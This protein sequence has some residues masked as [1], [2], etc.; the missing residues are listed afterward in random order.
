MASE[1]LLMIERNGYLMRWDN[2]RKRYVY[3]HRLVM[4]AH[5]GRHLRSDELVHHINHDKHDNRLE[6]LMVMSRSDHQRLHAPEWAGR[7]RPSLQR[8]KVPCPVCGE[9]FKPIRRSKGVDT[10]TCSVSCSNKLRPRGR[11]L[12]RSEPGSSC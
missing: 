4:E 3:D 7:P 1:R 5:L 10:K 12:A 11:A 9:P 6:N 2:D 8:P